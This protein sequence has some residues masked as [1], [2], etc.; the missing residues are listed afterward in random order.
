MVKLCRV[1]KDTFYQMEIL[2]LFAD[3]NDRANK[4]FA[5]ISDDNHSFRI[6]WNSDIEPVLKEISSGII[7]IGIDQHFSIIDF[8]TGKI[9]LNIIMRPKNWTAM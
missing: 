5:I 6:A 2:L 7:S 3:N 8:N 1:N 9:L 4:H